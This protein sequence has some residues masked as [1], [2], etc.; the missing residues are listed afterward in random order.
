MMPCYPSTTRRAALA[1][2]LAAFI[3]A[4]ACSTPLAPSPTALVAP[5]QPATPVSPVTPITPAPPTYVILGDSL[6]STGGWWPVIGQEI[7]ATWTNLGIGSTFLH[8]EWQPEGRGYQ[9]A[10]ARVTAPPTAFLMHAGANDTILHEYHPGSAATLYER[11]TPES[12]FA[13]IQRLA[14]AIATDYPGVPLYLAEVGQV[15][16]YG[17]MTKENAAV[18]AGITLAW[19][20]LPNVRRGP[21]M[22]DLAPD[23]GVHFTSAANVQTIAERWLAILR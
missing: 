1:A 18:R 19:Q 13:D 4:A 11:P 20:R 17:D 14:S 10:R 9:A 3:G 15:W 8:F 16:T 7:H 5:G 12:V 6:A 21:Q 23:D 22:A 2:T